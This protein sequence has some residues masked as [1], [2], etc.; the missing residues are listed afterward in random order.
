MEHPILPRFLNSVARLR[1]RQNSGGTD[2][3][4]R[5][6]I[7]WVDTGTVAFTVTESSVNE[8]VLVSAAASGATPAGA[9]GGAL[10]GTYPNP[11]IAASVAGAGLAETSDVLSVNVDG[12]TIEINSDTLRVKAGGIGANEIAST[13]VTLGSYG[14][15][16][17]SPTYTVDADGRLTAAANVT[18]TGTVP[19]GSAGG[20]LT[21]TYPNPTLT[22][23]GVSAST[24][25]SATQVPQITVDAKG[26]ATT[27]A[28]VTITGTVPGGS[29]GG[30]LTGTY[31]NPT[32]TTGAVT[33]AKMATAV[34]MVDSSSNLLVSNPGFET[35]DATGWVTGIGTAVVNT[36]AKRS[37]TYGWQETASAGGVVTFHSAAAGFAITAGSLYRA[38][39]WVKGVGA[40]G[41]IKANIWFYDVS[42]AL[43][44]QSSF[45]YAMPV[46]TG[47]TQFTVAAFAPPLAVT[48]AINVVGGSLGAAGVVYFDD[49]TVV[50]ASELVSGGFATGIT[51]ARVGI[52]QE[53]VLL[54][55]G[56]SGSDN[57]PAVV[58]ATTTNPGSATL[59]FNTLVLQPPWPTSTAQTATI[60]LASAS[61][62]SST[63]AAQATIKADTINLQHSGPVASVVTVA[64]E[65]GGNITTG[66]TTGTQVGTTTAQKL[67]FWAA[68]PVVQTTGG[69]DVLAGLVTVG[70]RAASSNPPLNLGTGAITGGTT[71]VGALTST[72]IAGTGTVA[73]T[74]TLTVTDAKNIVV[75]TTTGT[76][77]GT[78]TTQKL[79]FYGT[80]PVVQ[81]ANTVT[82]KA[83]LQT[84]GI[85]AAGGTADAVTNA[86]FGIFASQV[87]A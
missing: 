27:V 55:P 58:G 2:V 81:A 6:R 7:N 32:I 71:S 77:I 31:P 57:S 87:F 11:G 19:G 3:G 79:G 23:S 70:L 40:V 22:T 50:Q 21:G 85:I 68:T 15:A 8:E 53:N 17:Q 28:N 86:P 4:Q 47:F 30:D 78:G 51:G 63:T 5:Q 9:A 52:T 33:G 1:H 37:G 66:T 48:A 45:G 39:G 25:G 59:Q 10:D 24:Y 16:T 74:D 29:A 76:Q 49:F 80:T 41:T 20:D 56:D 42:N 72:S 12:S 13:A 44:Y 35:G 69:T 46:T 54:F 73:V 36:T 75:G 61:S 82:A 38:S 83:A 67:A 14:S 62:D 18:I 60:T 64:V 84:L 65:D 43:I 34:T 26:R